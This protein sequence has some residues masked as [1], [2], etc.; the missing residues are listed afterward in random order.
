ML[1]A[2]YVHDLIEIV[3]DSLVY[4]NIVFYESLVNKTDAIKYPLEN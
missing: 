4:V 3:L 1:W 2:V